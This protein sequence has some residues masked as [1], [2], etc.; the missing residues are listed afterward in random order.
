MYEKTKM[1][2][3]IRKYQMSYHNQKV[4]IW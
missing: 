4:N 2:V 3:I 1:S